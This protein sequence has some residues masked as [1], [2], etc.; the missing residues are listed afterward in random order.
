MIGLNLIT[1]TILQEKSRIENMLSRYQTELEDLPK[2][3]LSE[4][5]VGDKV[6]YYLKF[7][8]GKK[9]VSKYISKDKIDG[10]REQ[11][12]RRAHIEVM[13]GSL[14]EEKRIADKALEGTL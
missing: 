14:N 3:A 6:Y 11:L 2:G 10:L 12:T 5:R 8:E 9:V 1:H 7:R 13:I 4:K